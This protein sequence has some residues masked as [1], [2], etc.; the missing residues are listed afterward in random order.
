V[1]KITVPVKFWLLSLALSSTAVQAT[2]LQRSINNGVVEYS[3]QQQDTRAVS[4]SSRKTTVYKSLSEGTVSFSDQKPLHGDY[5]VL[6]YDCYACNPNSSIDW[7]NI[8]LDT[9]SYKSIIDN[10][11]KRYGVDKALIRA[12][13]HAESSFNPTA[14]SR[15]GAQGLMQLMP[16]TADDLGVADPFNATENING[17]TQYLAQLLKQFDG[18]SRL[19]TAAFN[20]GPNAVRK[21]AGIPPYAETKVYVER[22]AIL[23]ARYQNES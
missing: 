7:H 23:R 20:A 15:Q 1:V 17:G 12:V 11:A 2:Q 13:I 16:A 18:D 22:V 8:A 21:F 4:S 10:A 19:A 9:Q 5:E 6:H 14:V 3:Q